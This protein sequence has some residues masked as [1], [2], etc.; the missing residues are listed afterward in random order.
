MKITQHLK[1]YGRV[2][3]VFFRASMCRE[4][5]LLQVNGWVRNRRDG[6]VEAMLQGEMA[7]VE[8]LLDWT[9]RGPPGARVDH[10]EIAEGTG[11]YEDFTAH[12]S[13]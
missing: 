7:A 1:V 10:I 5:E 13:F 9:R 11:I 6:A 2:Q 8:Q 4:A 12:P 3:G